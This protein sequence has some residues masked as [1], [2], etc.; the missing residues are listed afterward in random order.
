MKKKTKENKIIKEQ[1]EKGVEQTIKRYWKTL[2]ALGEYD[3][4]GRL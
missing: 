4:T 3:K 2:K 1:I